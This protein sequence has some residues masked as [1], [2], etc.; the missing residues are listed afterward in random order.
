M[1]NY[2]LMR[3][4]RWCW[5]RRLVLNSTRSE[6]NRQRTCQE[7]PFAALSPQSFDLINLELIGQSRMSLI[8]Y[9]NIR[10][11]SHR[12]NIICI[13]NF[14]SHRWETTTMYY[15]HYV[16]MAMTSFQHHIN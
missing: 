13:G 1:Q 6:Y 11:Y 4:S 10:S 16:K 8:I 14:M 15:V 9:D 7:S 3:A 12:D 2:L 5:F